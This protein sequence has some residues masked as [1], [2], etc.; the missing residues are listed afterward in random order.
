MPSSHRLC[1]LSHTRTLPQFFIPSII[2]QMGFT[3]EASQVRTIP[4]YVA[5]VLCCWTS[6]YLADRFRHRYAF[7]MTGVVVASVGFALLLAQQHVAVEV[8][9]F[10]L[11]LVVGGGYSTQ[12]IT[13]AWL[14][15][16][17]SGHYKRGVASAC[18]IGFGN[19]GGI[20]ASTVFLET[21]A[22]RYV[23]G[24]SV[25]LGLMWLCAAACTVLY[26]GAVAENKKRDRGER[27]ARLTEPDA[28]N[29]GD[30]HP[31]WRLAT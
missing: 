18:Q 7:A 29:L 6:G 15:N 1:L 22:P 8:R 19:I 5:A 4:I 28:D 20:V 9:Y 16:M 27:D 26:G 31:A 25:S 24:Y 3:A 23:T 14:A 13:L 11:F 12:P 10:G 30:D 21:E 2:K 17:Q